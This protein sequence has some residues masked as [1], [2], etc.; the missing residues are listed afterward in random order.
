MRM[1]NKPAFF[2]LI[3]GLLLPLTLASQNTPEQD[4]IISVERIWDLAQHNAFTGLIEFNNKLYCSF[5]EGS[6]HVFGINGSVRVIA[7]DDGQNW[8]SVAHLYEKD[9][10]LRDPKL[11][12]T[13]DN[14]I[15]INIGGSV[16]VGNK[17]VKMIPMVS[18]SDKSGRNFSFPQKLV[19]DKKIKTDNDWLWRTTWHE[20]MAYAT[21]YQY[22]E[23][24]SKLQ[25]VKST[26]G[27]KF[28]YVTTLDLLGKP[29]ETTLRFKGD[30]MI[31]IVRRESESRFGFIGTS[32]PPYKKWKW[33]EL[34]SRLGGPD[35]VILPN[36]EM[37]IGTREYP[38]DFNQKM[39]LAKVT[40]EGNFRKLV[41]L[42]SGGDCSYPGLVVKDDIL[43]VSYYSSHEEKT[44]I[45][46]AK[47]WLDRLQHWLAMEETPA[48][49]VL[50]DKSGK[51]ELASPDKNAEI[52]YTLDGSDP[53]QS[54][55]FIYSKSIQISKS[56]AL[57]IQSYQ[58]GKLSS[59]MI[60]TVIG[61]DVYQSAQNVDTDLKP[62]L[63]YIY[64]E[65]KVTRTKD[66]ESLPKTANGISSKFSIDKRDRNENFAFHFEGYIDIPKDGL[67]TFYLSTNDG[68][69]LFL[70]GEE[71]INNDGP[72][73]EREVSSATSLREGKHKIG[74]KYFQL[75]GG[76]LL[77]VFWKG[78]GFEKTEIP[79]S[80]LF[81][82]KKMTVELNFFSVPG[83]KLRNKGEYFFM[84]K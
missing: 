64:H 14:R 68:S 78:S 3:I 76:H 48:P 69:M 70:N 51:V 20:G 13:P 56:T 1:N 49:F 81:H 52:R 44:A 60:V 18:F 4:A 37:I 40:T 5:R 15:M 35:L 38:A 33:E 65:G 75:G 66:I 29:N 43:Y 19:I 8:Y 23:T 77:K 57:R 42:P 71:F 31:A 27:I 54:E 25:L 10:D 7:S 50:S 53:T 11:S 83:H 72:H 74:L 47:V 17:L 9:I 32:I 24:E 82:L 84:N 58:P 41:T 26:D 2:I 46:L 39:I 12:V 63:F 55:G 16:Y 61:T 67:Y 22:A 62:G 21:V 6:A 30:K 34:D 73:G 36:G 80:V 28:N 59:K 45:Y 79:A